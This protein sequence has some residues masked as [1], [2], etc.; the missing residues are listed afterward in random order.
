[1]PFFNLWILRDDKI[2][3]S[4]AQYLHQHKSFSNDGL[5]WLYILKKSEFAAEAALAQHLYV[6]TSLTHDFSFPLH[7][8]VDFFDYVSSGNDNISWNQNLCAYG[9]S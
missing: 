3:F 7:N 4:F 6:L 5:F 1:M 9:V 8:I 2:N